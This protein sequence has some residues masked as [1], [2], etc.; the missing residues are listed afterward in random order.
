M[1][2]ALTQKVLIASGKGGVGKSCCSVFLGQALARH[3]FRVLLIELDAGMRGLDLML[4]MRERC[5]YDMGDVLKGMCDPYDAVTPSDSIHGLSLLSAPAGEWNEFQQAD[6]IWLC[7]EI[8]AYYDWIL[9]DAPAGIGRGFHLG[10]EAADRALVVVTPD[11]ICVRDA[12][13]ASVLLERARGSGFSQRLII[14]RVTK[15]AVGDSLPD[16]DAVIDQ[17][18]VQLIGVV[19][20]DSSVAL[21]AANGVPLPASAKAFQAFENIAWRLD[22]LYR[23]L[24]IQ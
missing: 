11:P 2:R 24:A 1:A 22:G 8:S 13:T 7:R 9:L 18:A 3:G 6:L 15:S 14:N 17:A 12:Y 20:E 23:P 19:P 4:G 16:L 21:S 5:P 10:L